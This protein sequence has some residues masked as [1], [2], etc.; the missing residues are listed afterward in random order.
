MVVHKGGPLVLDG[1]LSVK[2]GDG[3]HVRMIDGA[4]FCR[5]GQSK[6]QPFCDGAHIKAKFDK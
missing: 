1:N 5:C 6:N 2:L 4:A 3:S